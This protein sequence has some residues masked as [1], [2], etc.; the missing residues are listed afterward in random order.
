MN[1]LANEGMVQ[2]KHS[3]RRSGH[4][5]PAAGS[6]RGFTLVEA[7]IATLLMCFGLLA[8]G[9]MIFVAAASGSLARSQD[10]ASVAAQNKLE[11][12]TSVY[13]RTPDSG[14]LASGSHGPE[15]VQIL[16][17]DANLVLNRFD[18]SWTVATVTDPRPGKVLKAKQVVIT[19]VPVNSAGGRNVKASLNKTV[20]M[21]AIFSLR[22]S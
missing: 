22:L 14:D 5:L 13:N 20:T 19:V 2:L 8:A 21:T 18:V 10:G 11:F 6:D 12:L 3:M 7:L 4:A 1:S 16:N 9:Q 17:R 15:L